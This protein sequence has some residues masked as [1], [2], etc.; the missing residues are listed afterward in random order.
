MIRGSNRWAKRVELKDSPFIKKVLKSKFEA[1]TARYLMT[2]GLD[3]EDIYESL[4]IT[5]VKPAQKGNYKPDW[6]LPNGVIVETKGRFTAADRQKMVQVSKQHP[7]L[8]IRLVFYSDP[9]RTKINKGSRTT[10]AAWCEKNGFRWAWGSVPEAWLNEPEKP[11][12]FGKELPD[13]E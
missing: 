4:K 2:Q 5:Y 6:P 11:I 1:D 8:D 9:T 13:A 12:I 7:H 10:V 3:A